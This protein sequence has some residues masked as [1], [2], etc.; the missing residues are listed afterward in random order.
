M[1]N[2]NATAV[3]CS[4]RFGFQVTAV[5]SESPGAKCGLHEIDDFIICIKGV[6][7]DTRNKDKLV[8]TITH[9][10]LIELTLKIQKISILKS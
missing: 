7:L 1:G 8:T 3:A 4:E 5:K 9:W 10:W 2:T 6:P